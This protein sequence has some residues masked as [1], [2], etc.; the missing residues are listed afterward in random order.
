MVVAGSGPAGAAAALVLAQAGARVALVDPDRFPRDKACGDLLGPRGVRWCQD[1]GLAPSPARRV[2][3]LVVLGPT[4]RALTLPWPSS[5]DYPDHVLAV[6]RTTFDA[7]L[8]EAA[9]AAGAEPVRGRV[10]AVRRGDGADLAVD[11]ADGSSIAC[12]AVV[13]ADG[14]MS[15][16]A[17]SAGLLSP[18]RALW[19]FALRGYVETT[20]ADPLI[21]F[22][23]SRPRR[24]LPGYGWLF[25]G[26][27][28]RA[29]LGF[30][31]ALRDRR[32]R[33]VLARRLLPAFRDELVARGLLPANADIAP[34]TL[35]GGWIRMGAAGTM[36]A[37]GGVLLAGDAAGLVNPLQGEG[38]AEALLSGA[39]AGAAILAG[40]A[41]AAERYRA[42]LAARHGRFLPASATLHVGLL[43]RPGTL[44]AAGRLITAPVIGAALARGW[45][46]YWNDLLPGAAPGRARTAASALD[47]GIRAFTGSTRRHR[48]I[49][50]AL[51]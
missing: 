9:L 43:S 14:A 25:P 23:E 30:G 32:E 42:A 6:P 26:P 46:V 35:R 39:D 8:R 45:S 19:G 2:G 49:A 34:G 33:A 22:C 18:P 48:E 47:H 44:A 21:V 24:A 1:L 20:V 41:G 3:D 17:A 11:L 40:P 38:M 28:G 51:S 13:G 50:A 7:M 16:V 12:G 29:N 27:D 5:A 36:P 31:V 15:R 4:G 10:A 37:R